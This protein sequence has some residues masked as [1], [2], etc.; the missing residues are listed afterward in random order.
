MAAEERRLVAGKKSR[1]LKRKDVRSDSP[2]VHTSISKMG[3]SS[4][5]A[6]LYM[7]AV[8]AKRANPR[9]ATFADR[10]AARG[11]CQMEIIV[12]V[13][14]KLLHF[15]YGVLKSGQPFDPDFGLVSTAAS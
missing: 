3:R 1:E 7:S 14:R 6:A 5:R 8:V 12:A 15:A 10:L 9:L 2:Q 4:I 11:L 13:M